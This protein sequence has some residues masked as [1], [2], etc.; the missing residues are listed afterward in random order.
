MCKINGLLGYCWSL[1]LFILHTFG[2]RYMLS[3]RHLLKPS[4]AMKPA[5]SFLNH[6]CS[7]AL[8]SPEQKVQ[9]N[10]KLSR[11]HTYD[12][13]CALNISACPSLQIT[14][15]DAGSIERYTCA[16]VFYEPFALLAVVVL[17][18]CW[19][20]RSELGQRPS[21][22]PKERSSCKTRS[23]T[24]SHGSRSLS[25]AR[26]WTPAQQR[27]RPCVRSSVQEHR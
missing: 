13:P 24:S 9:I 1:G 11:Q 6:M 15:H 10:T 5:Y 2:S 3:W 4:E 17:W 21:Y 12:A 22:S 25:S 18:W 8:L 20:G 19:E 16:P 23:G 26:V 27:C 7:E 14:P